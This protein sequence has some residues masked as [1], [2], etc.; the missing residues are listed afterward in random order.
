[1]RFKV[2]SSVVASAVAACVAFS[3]ACAIHTAPFRD[4]RGH[5]ISGSVATMTDEVIG[6]VEQRLWFRGVDVGKPALILLH[7]G[8]GASELALFRHFNADLER[9][10]LV[11]YWEQR[12]GTRRR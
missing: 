9:A 1:M 8:P 10:F 4:E 3:S 12:R 5:V 7:G 6:G 2:L 11:V